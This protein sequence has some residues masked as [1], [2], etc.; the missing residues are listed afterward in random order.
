MTEFVSLLERLGDARIVIASYHDDHVNYV[1]VLSE[2]MDELLS[3]LR[4]C[5]PFPDEPDDVFVHSSSGS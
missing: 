4:F 3:A 1:L 2:T 5:A